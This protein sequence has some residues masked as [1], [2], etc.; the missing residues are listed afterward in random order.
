MRAEHGP[1][2]PVDLAPGVPA[3]LVIGYDQARRILN[4]ELRFPADPRV[5]ERAIPDTCPVR[6]MMEWRP[7]A[8]RSTGPEHSRYRAANT[9][10]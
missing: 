4:D 5:W 8:L 6:P 3:T 1:L 7:N 9:A 10:C 2:V